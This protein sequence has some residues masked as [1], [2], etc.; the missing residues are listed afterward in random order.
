M[1]FCKDALIISRAVFGLQ[2][3]VSRRIQLIGDAKYRF[4]LRILV[5]YPCLVNRLLLHLSSCVCPQQRLWNS[6]ADEGDTTK[7][8]TR[9]E[10]VS[11]SKWMSLLEPVECQVLHKPASGR[12]MLGRLPHPSKEGPCQQLLS[13]SSGVR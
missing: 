4:R 6:R 8:T 13:C 5:R 2:S 10:S 7:A 1:V 9:S 11:A 12:A 3:L